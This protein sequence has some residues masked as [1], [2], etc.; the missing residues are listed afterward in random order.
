MDKVNGFA[1]QMLPYLDVE[2]PDA[3]MFSS[4]NDLTIRV[5]GEDRR[6]LL[7]EIGS[8]SN[9]LAYHVATILALR[10]FFIKLQHG[11]VPQFVIFDQP[12]QAYFPKKLA[13]QKPAEEP[14]ISDEDVDAVRKAFNVFNKFVERFPAKFQII[15]LDHA[16]RKSGETSALHLI[17]EWRDGPKL[18][19]SEWLQ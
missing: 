17:E 4:I 14:K 15:V 9:W 6:N 18:V 12:S 16:S 3:P 19:P 11:P 7:S 8:G 10:S 5:A 13:G 1:A 2:D